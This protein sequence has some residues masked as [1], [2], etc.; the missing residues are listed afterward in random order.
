MKEGYTGHDSQT[1]GV[2]E[3]R[4]VGGKGDG[5]LKSFT[6]GFLTTCGLGN[7]GTP[8]TDQGK[9][10]GLHGTIGNT[11]ADRASWDMDRDRIVVRARISQ[12]EIFAPKLVLDRTLE[13]PLGENRITVKDR[14]QNRGDVREACMILYHMNLGYPL[15]DEDARLFIPSRTV[16]PRNERAREG[17]G[18]W[19]RMEKPQK[20]FE[21][22]C[23][24]HEMEQGRAELY[25]PKLRKGLRI[26][27]DPSVLPFFTQW[28]MMGWRDYV[29]GLEPGNCTADGRDRMR[30]D[31]CLKELEPGETVEYA[32]T[33]EAYEEEVTG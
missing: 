31:G 16:V 13:C 30:R 9:S 3:H 33:I 14:I 25:Q 28:K 10:F 12:E 11:P 21:E 8:C 24:Y 15:L 20:G 17:I 1:A 4:L 6:A 32:V 29:L 2:E 7:V 22:Q 18:G 26:L 23:Y 5:F 27:Y 19:N